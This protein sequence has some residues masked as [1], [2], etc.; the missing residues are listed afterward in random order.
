MEIYR[1]FDFIPYI[2][3]VTV[4]QCAKRIDVKKRMADGL[5]KRGLQRTVA[6]EEDEGIVTK[7]DTKGG[8]NMLSTLLRL[9]KGINI[10]QRRIQGLPVGRVKK[11]S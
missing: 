4:S 6:A 10:N 9:R 8:S 2:L 3:V 5:A 11:S 1:L 7:K